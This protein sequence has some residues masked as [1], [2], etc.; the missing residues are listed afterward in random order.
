MFEI[1]K[2]K[3]RMVDEWN[4]FMFRNEEK[5]DNKYKK[6]MFSNK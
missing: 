6:N 3:G 2:L 1:A 5:P 4:R